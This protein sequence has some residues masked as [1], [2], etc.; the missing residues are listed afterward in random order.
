MED[1]LRAN[2]SAHQETKSR[3]H[4]D[5]GQTPSPA[6]VVGVAK[7]SAELLDTMDSSDG[8]R[9]IRPTFIRPRTKVG[10]TFIELDC[11]M[12]KLNAKAKS[13]FAEKKY[14]LSAKLLSYAIAAKPEKRRRSS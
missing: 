9:T 3:S 12:D 4:A 14:N 1:G 11:G 7:Q 6:P 5:H 10:E 8:I 13:A 2:L